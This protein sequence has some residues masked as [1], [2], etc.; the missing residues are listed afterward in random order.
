VNN[1]NSTLW[2]GE[3]SSNYGGDGW[4]MSAGDVT[5]KC[6]PDDWSGRFWPRTFCSFSQNG[7]CSSVGDNCCKTG[8]C[9]GDDEKTFSLQCKDSGV[10]PVTVAEF[11]LQVLPQ[12]DYYDVSLVDGGT[13]P[14]E[15]TVTPGTF[16]ANSD[17]LYWCGNPG[18]T[19]ATC[20]N[21]ELGVCNWEFNSGRYASDIQMVDP[22]TCSLDSDCTSGKCNLNTHTCNCTSNSDCGSTEICGRNLIPGVGPVAACGAL[23]GWWAPQKVCAIDSSI[24]SPLSCSAAVDGQGTNMDLYSCDGANAQ[25]CYNAAADETC[26]GCPSWSPQGKCI[27]TNPAWTDVA[28]PIVSIFKTACPT[29]YSYPYDDLTSTFVCSGSASQMPEYTI[30]FCPAGSPGSFQGLEVY[31]M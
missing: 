17:D 5:Q 3:T 11:T 12:S 23:L 28:E 27:S 8:G 21:T 20:Q 4:E 29:A 1:C 31:P 15:I 25:S 16:Q 14:I 24:G 26:C 10:P 2:I 13:I 30:T 6:V 18:C 9:V 22:S 19:A 7:T